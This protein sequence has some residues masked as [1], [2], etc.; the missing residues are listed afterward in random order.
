V[1]LNIGGKTRPNEKRKNRNRER[2]VAIGG[3]VRVRNVAR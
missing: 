2:K 1:E 3:L